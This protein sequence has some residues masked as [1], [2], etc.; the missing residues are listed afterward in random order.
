MTS[1]ERV[2]TA[3]NFKEPD[4]IPVDLGGHRSS[5]M[6]AIAYGKLRKHLALPERPVRV[7]DMVQQLAIIDE[8]VLDLFGIDTIEMGRGFMRGDGEWKPWILPD[9]SPC[10]IPWYVNLEQH[11]NDWYVYDDRGDELGVMKKG[12]LYFEQTRWPLMERGV[13]NDDFHDL[14]EMLGRN[15]WSAVAHPGA[16]LPMDEAG[17]KEMEAGARF[18]RNSTERAI[19][20]L[21]GGNMFELPQMLYRMDNYLLATAMY[22]DK[23]LELSEALCDIHLRNLEKWLSAVGPYIDVVL[24]GDDLGGQQGPLISPDT[25]RTLY[26]PYHQK[27]WNRAK[28]LA[29]VKV[30]LHCCGGIYELLPDLIEAG[31]DAINPVQVSCRGMDP[32]RLKSE[33]GNRITFWGGGCDTQRILPMATPAEVRQNVRELTSVFSP[34]GGFVFQ[35]VHNVLANVPPENVVAMLEAVN[36]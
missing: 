13:E 17:L 6:A 14:E 8:D 23:A 16:H 5:G 25:Y 10:E 15:I 20:G 19:I 21:F 29:D 1:R 7:Y 22:M 11:G 12:S 32:V 9:G 35:Q 31:L 34:G 18:L 28:E 24:F 26:K 36:P 4:R 2:L 27:L 30:Q 33:F 3:L